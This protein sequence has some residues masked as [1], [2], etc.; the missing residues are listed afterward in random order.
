MNAPS[1]PTTSPLQLGN[2]RRAWNWFFFESVDPRATAAV[3]IA[4]GILLVLMLAV[5]LPDIG[6]WYSKSGVLPFDVSRFVI[7]SDT[8]TIFQW[9]PDNVSAVRWC[10]GIFI[11]QALLLLL[12]VRPRLQA[13][14]VLMWLTSFQHR[15]C[16]LV[17]GGNTVFRLFAFLLVLSP[18]GCRWSIDSWLHKKRHGHLPDL[19]KCYGWAV[20]LMQIQVT[21][22]YAST[23]WE[24]LNGE[25]WLN[26]TA[27]YYTSR[28][29]D[30]FGRGPVPDM[31]FNDLTA[32]KVM[33][34]AVLATEVLLPIGLWVRETR[35][36]AIVAAIGLHLSIEW[37]MHLFLFEW[38]MIAALLSFVTAADISFMK[39]LF[40][41]VL[42]PR[43][44]S[45]DSMTARR[46]RRRAVRAS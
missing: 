6:M 37:M 29:D 22:I 20:R 35:G 3:R 40:S 17:D 31:L 46:R 10:Y 41:R 44:R 16:L 36:I 32:L 34:W 1:Q 33:T 39:S 18:C 15:N 26:G 42:S 21:V 45:L 13:I 27:L 12:G 7:D 43:S 30:I 5:E 23:A 25:A 2:L 19:S 14:C 11:V 9:L 8:W 28:L 38:I 24:K 4:Y